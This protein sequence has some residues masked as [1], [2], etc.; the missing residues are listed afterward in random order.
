MTIAETGLPG[1]AEDERPAR[2]DAEVGRLAGPQG[3]APEDLLDAERLERRA[4]VVVLADR[5]AAGDDRD[6]AAERQLERVA[7]RLAVVARHRRRRRPRRRSPR[8]AAAPRRRSSCGSARA[9]AARRARPA[10]RRSARTRAVG[11]ERSGPRRDRRR[12]ARRARRRRAGSPRSRIESP[13]RTS[14]PARRTAVPSSTAASMSTSSPSRLV[15]STR[16]TASAPAGSTAPVEIAIASPAPSSRPAG[17]PARDSSTIRSRRGVSAGPSVSAARTANPSIAEL[18]K[19]GTSSA[20]TI[21][22]ARIR[23][24]A[25]FSPTASDRKRDDAIERPSGARPRSS[26]ALGPPLD[27]RR[28]AARLLP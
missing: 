4:D 5:D 6:V 24:R 16:T 7:G 27:H 14:S 3:H 17:W 9:R 10:R 8:R 20:A 21:A 22:S 26:S 18:S 12:R 15:S 25:S 2:G 1:S 13:A 19:P 11:G 23:P 28:I